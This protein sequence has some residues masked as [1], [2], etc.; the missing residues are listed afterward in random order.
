M[1]NHGLRNVEVNVPVRERSPKP[2]ERFTQQDRDEA[3]QR[4][5]EA[6]ENE[7]IRRGLPKIVADTS[8]SSVKSDAARA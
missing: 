3:D 5:Q 4:L 8:P 7:R 6:F 1:T 2:P